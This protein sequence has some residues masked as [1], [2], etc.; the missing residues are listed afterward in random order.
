MREVYFLVDNDVLVSPSG[1]HN[2]ERIMGWSTVSVQS[3][4]YDGGGHQLAGFLSLC[5]TYGVAP[6][7]FLPCSLHPHTLL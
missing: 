4:A 7:L 1:I 5:H 2:L 6:F 3:S